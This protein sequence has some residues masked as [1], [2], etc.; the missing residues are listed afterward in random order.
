MISLHLQLI[1]FLFQRYFAPIIM[2]TTGSFGKGL[3]FGWAIVCVTFNLFNEES[4]FW[5][6]GQSKQLHKLCFHYRRAR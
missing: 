4:R 3:L 1:F 5:C 2:R 6:L